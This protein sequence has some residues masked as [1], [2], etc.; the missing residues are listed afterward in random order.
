MSVKANWDFKTKYRS[1]SK[2]L[3]ESGIPALWRML[4]LESQSDIPPLFLQEIN[5]QWIKSPEFWAHKPLL[6]SLSIW[7]IIKHGRPW[8]EEEVQLSRKGIGGC[9]ETGVLVLVLL[10]RPARG[11]NKWRHCSFKPK[12]SRA[13]NFRSRKVPVN[14]LLSKWLLARLF[15]IL[16]FWVQVCWEKV[17]QG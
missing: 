1:D 2:C 7:F 8:Q 5:A 15:Y 13:G 16:G 3:P 12:G 6:S 14:P 10:L 11:I 17:F 4:S 9:Q